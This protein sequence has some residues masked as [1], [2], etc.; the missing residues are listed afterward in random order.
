MHQCHDI[1][2][3]TVNI[4]LKQNDINLE[5]KNRDGNTALMIAC[6][7]IYYSTKYALASGSM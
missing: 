3:K 1:N 2:I 6:Y 4:L 5:I 7:D